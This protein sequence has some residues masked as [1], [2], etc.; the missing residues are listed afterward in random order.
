MEG[1]FI[2]GLQGIFL[3]ECLNNVNLGVFVQMGYDNDD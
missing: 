3:V 2:P 1:V